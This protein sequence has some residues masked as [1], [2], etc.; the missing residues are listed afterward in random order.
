[1][2]DFR[3]S[4]NNLPALYQQAFRTSEVAVKEDQRGNKEVARN[5]YLEVIKIFETIL[6]LESD[7]K[8]KNSV[9]AKGQEYS[10][11]A[12]QL[13]NELRSSVSPL[14]RTNNNVTARLPLSSSGS[15]L[16]RAQSILDQAIFQE[17]QKNEEEALRLYVNAVELFMEAKKDAQDESLKS[18][19]DNKIRELLDLAEGLKGLPTKPRQTLTV[20]SANPGKPPSILSPNLKLTT[21]E[22]E[23]IKNSSYINNKIF[24]PWSE[25]DLQENFKYDKPFIHLD[26]SN[27]TPELMREL[28]YDR[29]KAALNDD[30]GD[31]TIVVSTYDPD[32]IGDFTLT[33]A[34]NITFKV[35]PLPPEGAG[36][37]KRTIQGE[38]ISGL[39]AKGGVNNPEYKYNPRYHLTIQEMTMIKIRLQTPMIKPTPMVNVRIFEKHPTKMLGREVGS[40][41][42]YTNYPQGVFMDDV[43]LAPNKEGNFTC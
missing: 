29:E 28:G 19:L 26:E 42:A 16:N 38:W 27:W 36:L 9:W 43:S 32:M 2:D 20:R 1:M 8:Q 17:N 6:R 11:R 18:K 7:Q 12:R 14:P 5:S 35:T 34:S 39:N 30:V 25:I 3:G 4:K 15:V 10:I 40:S 37:F 24:L 33:V 31:Y 22:I 21:E 13:D 23:I 41:G